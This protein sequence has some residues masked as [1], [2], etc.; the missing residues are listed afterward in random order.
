M[1]GMGPHIIH[2]ENYIHGH[3]PDRVQIYSIRRIFKR[4]LY[5]FCFREPSIVRSESHEEKHQC[6]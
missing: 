5:N 4:T 6:I 2:K 1:S 3:I